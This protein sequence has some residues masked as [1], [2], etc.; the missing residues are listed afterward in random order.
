MAST[1]LEMAEAH[2]A[3]VQRE[4]VSLNER[5]AA[6]DAEI[7][8]L[9]NYLQEGRTTVGAE[10]AKQQEVSPPPVPQPTA[11]SSLF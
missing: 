9:E 11:Q 1:V 6:I 4:I 7:A 8:K 5:K 2:L 3:N 10:V